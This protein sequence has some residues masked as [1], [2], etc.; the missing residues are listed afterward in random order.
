[1]RKLTNIPV[2]MVDEEKEKPLEIGYMTLY[3]ILY[4]RGI[5]ISKMRCQK[6]RKA[7]IYSCTD[8]SKVAEPDISA[9]LLFQALYLSTGDVTYKDP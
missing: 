7:F 2:V 5:C 6:N 4:G 3:A 8:K 9:G 1:M